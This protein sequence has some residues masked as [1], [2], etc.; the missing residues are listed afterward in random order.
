MATLVLQTAGAAIGS[1]LG[2]PVGAAIGQAAGAIAGNILDRS[3]LGSI[4]AKDSFGP[5]L[6]HMP[7]VAAS[8]GIPVPKV[9]G[10]A[11]VGG[12]LIWMTRF[13]EVAYTTKAGK[14]GGKGGSPKTT[15]FRYFANFAV[16]LC[17]GPIAEV[18]R[19]WADG[20][21][22]DQSNL[23]IR[24][25]PGSED[26]APDP[27]IVAK[28]GAEA[29]P[30]YRGIAYVVF[31]RLPLDDF[32]NRF[33]LLSFEVVRPVGALGEKIKAVCIIPGSSENGY[34]PEPVLQY[35]GPGVTRGDN[36]HQ[37]YKDSDWNASL[38]SLQALCPNLESV[39]LVV[40][41]FGDDLR[42]GHCK[43]QP[44]VEIANKTTSGTPWLV[45]GQNRYTT[46]EVSS[47]E[48]KPAYGG[49]PADAAVVRAIQ[50][51]NARGLKV[52]FYPF[53]MMDIPHGNNLPDPWSG[54]TS[55]PPYP[56][57]GRITCDPAPGQPDS[58]DASAAANAQVGSFFGTANPSPSEWSFRRFIMHY[59][60]LCKIAGGVDAFLIGSELVALTRVRSASGVYP[61]VTQLATLAHDAA[62]M[63]GAQTRVSYAADWTEYGAHV[64]D[65]GAEVRFPLDPL[66]A[67]PDISFV[68]I[69][70]Y[71]PLSDWREGSDHADAQEAPGI[72]DAEYLKGRIG[73]GE[74][75]D[76]YYADDAG[77][78]AQQRLPITDGAYGKPWIFRPKDI[79]NWWGNL[80]YERFNGVELTNPTPWEAESKPVWLTETGCPAVDKGSNAPNVFPDP[81]S[82]ESGLP[83]F[84]NGTR[85]DLILLRTL[86]AVSDR[87]TDSAEGF[88]QAWNPQSGRY[89]G[90]MLD[91]TRIYFW[92]W[93]ARPFPAFP[94]LSQTWADASSWQTGHWMNGRLEAATA[95]GLL[96]SITGEYLDS[97]AAQI[98][99]DVHSLVDGYVL[100]RPMSARQAIAPL[101]AVLG[102]DARASSGRLSFKDRGS[103][104]AV[105]IETEEFAERGRDQLVE[106]VRAQ[107]SE[108]SA[109]L[110]LT[111]YDSESEYQTRTYQSRRQES[112]SQRESNMEIP[113]AMAADEARTR[114]H[115]L[116]QDGWAA[117]ETIS[118][119]LPPSSLALEVGDLVSLEI[120]NSERRF[121]ISRIVDG[122]VRLVE[123]RG[124]EPAMYRHRASRLPAKALV[125]PPVFGPPEV[126]ILD[127]AIAR[128]EAPA[129]QYIA[130]YADPWPGS[131][132]LWR[133]AGNG[134]FLFV[135]RIGAPA[136]IG[137]TLASVGPGQASRYDRAN[138]VDVELAFGALESLNPALALS[139]E[140]AIALQ[141]PDGAWEIMTY[142]DAELIGE[143]R[144]RLSGLVRGIG[145]QEYLALR[146]VAAG[147][148]V[149]VLDDAVVP[150]TEDAA[151]INVP[152]VYRIGP[153]RSDYS[154]ISYT[155]FSA[156]A[157]ALAMRPYA[158]AH[159]TARRTPE[160]VVIAFVR[161]SRLG[162]DTWEI[163]NPPLAEDRE[164]YEVEV[165]S[166]DIVVRTLTSDTPQAFYA[167]A[168]ETA[169]FGVAQ[170]ELKLNI[171]QLSLR[172]GRG[173]PR[174]IVVAV[175]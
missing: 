11:R 108:L 7:A 88:Q 101:A 89:N 125:P 157:S 10:R 94:A 16:G 137:V 95:A 92:A 128:S 69:D 46:L 48:G 1:M 130:V 23:V 146:T 121:L 55:Q 33:P 6:A 111:V 8:E 85:D 71:W 44:R 133:A 100:D 115:I 117:S 78:S 139:G 4:G 93:D 105:A 129:L 135:A 138:H 90:R 118:F 73:A 35:L 74:G 9:Y 98:D 22:L 3:I 38:D 168:Q 107:E 32:G 145:G 12:T 54:A 79:V 104:K 45:A 53:L 86:E 127:I 51:L 174:S 167:S 40:T 113:V 50:D 65:G 152:H 56:W 31:E 60:S 49:T 134:G 164:A 161:R 165:L 156:T 47:H 36:R 18:R 83:P 62:E 116:L 175:E 160:G 99:C 68:G 122:H 61:A 91:A 13:E 163:V 97:S 87:F 120:N 131:M 81:K 41:W 29:A 124:L 66:W 37:L 141:G 148:A 43:V 84:S 34:D 106:L 14:S 132:A 162:A 15:D 5:R 58:V 143:R 80:H 28:E 173:F 70:A 39:A 72:Y 172:F 2:G 144:Y 102:F 64:L 57:R 123:G 25:H 136:R 151:D 75:Y 17:E 126:R 52:V 63:L 112:G 59:A 21:E 142:T 155:E 82:S 171:F 30:S 119:A 19:I 76:W 169:D 166:G 27:L 149:V 20:K 153:A 150:L 159:V 158:P 26:Q 42:V 24:V 103:L 110:S 96:R 109:S 77:R 140:P 154:D 114:A 67:H 170:V 147:A